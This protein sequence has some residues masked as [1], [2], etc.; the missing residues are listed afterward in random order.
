VDVMA[1]GSRIPSTMTTVLDGSF[2]CCFWD[3][4]DDDD[5]VEK[6]E[7]EV[8]YVLLLL[9]V[10]W[11]L[12]RARRRFDFVRRRCDLQHAAENIVSTDNL[13]YGYFYHFA[14]YSSGRRRQG[15]WNEV[16]IF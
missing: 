11:L 1:K 13:F 6:K 4:F 7:E 8:W 12:R 10:V 15:F 3:V 5:D 14:L 9:V 16:L 2:F